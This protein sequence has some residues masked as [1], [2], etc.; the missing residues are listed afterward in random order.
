[1]TSPLKQYNSHG[2]L[3]ELAQNINK[4]ELLEHHKE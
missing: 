1:M 4:N 3:K 2:E